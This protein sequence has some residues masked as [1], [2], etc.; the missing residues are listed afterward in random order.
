MSKRSES[1]FIIVEV[2]DWVDGVIQRDLAEHIKSLCKLLADDN[3]K[4]TVKRVKN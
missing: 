1:Q 3:I 2:P 4:V